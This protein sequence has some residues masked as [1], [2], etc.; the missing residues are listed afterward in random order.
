MADDR[1]YNGIPITVVQNYEEM[2]RRA[3]D[4][5]LECIHTNPKL[6]LL[7]PTGTTPMGT[8][9]ILGQQDSRLFS[10]VKFLNMDEYCQEDGQLIPA[11][12][13]A[14]YRLFMGTHLFD[15][16]GNATSFFPGP[17]NAQM[18]GS[19]DTLILQLGGIDFCLTTMGEDGHTFGFN[20]P[21]TSFESQTRL[22]RVHSETKRVNKNLTGFE[23][24]DYAITTGINTGMSAREVLFLVSG[25]RKAEKLREVVYGSITQD[26]PATVLRTH[27]NCTWI[28]DEDAAGML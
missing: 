6:S 23:T 13:P 2:S 4:I 18:P 10:D 17:E 7:V 1:A 24:L 28:V 25:R 22:V 12:H 9:K 15:H 3:A 11:T 16:I 14:S 21:G 19:Y 5:I 27:Q 26:V 20:F 8:Y